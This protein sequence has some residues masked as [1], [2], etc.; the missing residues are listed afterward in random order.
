MHNY[1]R[2]SMNILGRQVLNAAVVSSLLVF[3]N[4]YATGLGKI[5]VL[6]SLG[7]PLKAEIEITAPN[8]EEMNSLIPKIASVEAFRQANIEFNPALLSLHFAIEQ[9]G[10]AYVVKVTSSQAMNEPYVDF[11]LEMTAGSG[12]MVREYTILLDPAELATTQPAQISNGNS[13]LNNGNKSKPV[14]VKSST[15]VTPADP[16]G[17]PEASGASHSIPKK[18]PSRASTPVKSELAVKPSKL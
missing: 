12:K 11:L 7:Q 13:S 2:L 16:A 10:S 14:A 17:Q 9:R 8:K 15:N 4:A 18:N 1:K 3:S 6:S 5:T